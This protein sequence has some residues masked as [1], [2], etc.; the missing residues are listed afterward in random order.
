MYNLFHSANID[1]EELI[2]EGDYLRLNEITIEM[3]KL[4]K[5][6]LSH[7]NMPKL[8]ALSFSSSLLR[9][10]EFPINLQSIIS[11]NLGTHS[12]MQTTTA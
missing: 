9:S 5:C 7:A 2:M 3:T 11:V 12:L 4:E 6:D 1:L 10:F 8:V